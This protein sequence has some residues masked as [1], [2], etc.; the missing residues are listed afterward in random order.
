[1]A[2]TVWVLADDCNGSFVRSFGGLVEPASCRQSGD[3]VQAS[4]DLVC[5]A[6]VVSVVEDRVEI[7][8]VRALVLGQQL[9]QG[10]PL[11]PRALRQLLGD[12]VGVV[13][14]HRCAAALWVPLNQG[15]QHALG[16]ERTV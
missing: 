9:A 5:V 4:Y 16:E 8:P 13:A 7:Q 6:R 12:P 11:V 2:G 1:M 3:L 10:G 15:E 14:A